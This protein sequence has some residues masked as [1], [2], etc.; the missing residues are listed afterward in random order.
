MVTL[1][2]V[3]GDT[4]DHGGTVSVPQSRV[5][6]G[7]R[8]VASVGDKVSCPRCNVI[9]TIVEGNPHADIDGAPIAEVGNLTSCG[10]R[11]LSIK[12]AS[13]G[14]DRET[15]ARAGEAIPEVHPAATGTDAICEPCLEEAARCGKG[16]VDRE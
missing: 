12:Q 13:V 15:A 14:F 5:D 1:W 6:I 9:A 7:G 11:L 2:I 4:T 16:L 10:A 3:D 8:N